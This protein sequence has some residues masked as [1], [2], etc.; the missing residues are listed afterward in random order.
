MSQWKVTSYGLEAQKP[1]RYTIPKN[2]LREIRED[3][4]AEWPLHM[5]EKNWVV[6]SDFWEAWQ[7][8]VRRHHKGDFGGIDLDATRRRLFR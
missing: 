1:D 7:R 4:L 6:M 8:A 3:T 2:R 5:S